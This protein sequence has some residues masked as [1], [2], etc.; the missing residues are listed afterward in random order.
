[1]AQIL[2]FEGPDGVLYAG[3]TAEENLELMLKGYVPVQ[4]EES[5]LT[6]VPWPSGVGDNG[7]ANRK[8]AAAGYDLYTAPEG[9]TSADPRYQIPGFT[10]SAGASMAYPGVTEDELRNQAQRDRD[11]LAVANAESDVLNA[12]AV[13]DKAFLES[14]KRASEQVNELDLLGVNEEF[15]RSR[16]SQPI[17]QIAAGVGD[18]QLKRTMAD[19]KF[20]RDVGEMAIALREHQQNIQHQVDLES[21][22]RGLNANRRNVF[23]EAGIFTTPDSQDQF[24]ST[25]L[26]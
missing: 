21:L 19:T 12:N 17:H 14:A 2:V 11:R 15:D 16:R 13:S 24:I 18:Q 8:R 23:A 7:Q 26:G 10:A 20:D 4:V 3:D 6:E 22:A 9:F 1:M 25:I 5:S